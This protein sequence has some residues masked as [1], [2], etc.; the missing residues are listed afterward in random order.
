MAAQDLRKHS[1]RGL[2]SPISASEIGHGISFK[3]RWPKLITQVGIDEAEIT[4]DGYLAGN[5]PSE[6]DL[7]PNPAMRFEQ[8]RSPIMSFATR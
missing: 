4:V 7:S 3:H 1:R 2:S 6:F 8:S 5:G